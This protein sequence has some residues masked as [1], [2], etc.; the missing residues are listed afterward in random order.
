[1]GLEEASLLLGGNH[2]LLRSLK[3][4]W[5]C[6]SFQFRRASEPFEFLQ[7]RGASLLVEL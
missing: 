1:M 3:G 6:L 5:G 2:R 7:A 4:C